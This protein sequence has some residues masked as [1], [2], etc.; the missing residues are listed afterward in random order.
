MVAAT[1]WQANAQHLPVVAIE[2]TAE[3]L[4]LPAASYDLALAN[5]VLFFVADQRAALQ[6]LRRVLGPSG[7]VVL[8]TNAA[9]HSARLMALHRA[10]AQRLGYVPVDRVLARFHLGHLGF[11]QEAFPN[12]E[13]FVREDAFL[14]PSVDA[15]L[16]YY[17]SGMVDAIADPPGDG[18]HRPRLLEL[19]GAEVEAII[20]REGVFRVPK[21][22]G[23]FVA[24]I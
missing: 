21:N 17:G 15:A 19:V 14:F 1:Q 12:A 11:V 3:H 6:E 13:R 4:P 9:D 5:H 16:A 18:S 2:A 22:T 8:T 24:Q 23:C 7:R 10:A 20:A